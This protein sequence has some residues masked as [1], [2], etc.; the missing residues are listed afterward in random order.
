MTQHTLVIN[1]KNKKIDDMFRLIEPSSGQ[2]YTI[3]LV[4]PVSAYAL[5]ECTSTMVY[6]WPDDGSMSRNM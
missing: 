6:I 3:V 2:I 1:I 5:T 4:H